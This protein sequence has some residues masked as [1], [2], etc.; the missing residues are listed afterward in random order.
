MKNIDLSIIL[1]ARMMFLFSNPSYTPKTHGWP[2][3][4][5]TKKGNARR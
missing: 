1:N 5:N 4:A 3:N 2:A